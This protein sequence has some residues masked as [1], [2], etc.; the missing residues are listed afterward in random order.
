M[1]VENGIS[2]S[3]SQLVMVAVQVSIV[4][5][6]VG[7]VSKRDLVD[8]VYGFIIM[9]MTFIEVRQDHN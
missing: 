4:P 8:S 9:V 5:M 6:R 3:I 1:D 7:T 2:N